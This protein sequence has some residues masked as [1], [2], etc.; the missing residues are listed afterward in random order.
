[1]MLRYLAVAAVSA[2]SVVGVAAEVPLLT[3][4]DVFTLALEHDP[5]YAAAVAEQAAGSQAYRIRRASVRPSLSANAGVARVDRRIESEF[6]TGGTGGAFEENY[7]EYN[8][9][10]SLTQP[11]FRWDL[12][13]QLDIGRVE[14]VAAEVALKRT[15]Q[16]LMGRLARAYVEVLGA[17]DG[18]QTAQSRRE[19]VQRQL[20]QVR[21]QVDV[22]A[23]AITGLREAEAEFDLSEAE[24]ID[25]QLR[26]DDAV[27]QLAR[28]IGT[29]AFEL[30]PVQSVEPLQEATSRPLADWLIAAQER[31]TNVVAARLRAEVARLDI[32]TNESSRLPQLDLT[33]SY[34]RND[35]SESMIGQD[36]EEGRIGLN[37]TVPIFTG[38]A[39]VARLDAAR[40]TYLQ[41][42][43][44]LRAARELAESEVRT[45]WR[46]VRASKRRIA[47]RE[48][49]MRSTRTALR[50]V[51]DG[52]EVGTRTLSDV[53]AAEQ[54]ALRAIQ[55]FNAAR[56]DYVVAVV[57]LK[58]AAGTV[59]DA[60]IP[61]IDAVFTGNE[62]GNVK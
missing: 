8:Y 9:G 46:T 39:N 38:G 48:R 14:V 54:S 6:F 34:G 22:G 36:A 30:A 17:N 26:V 62:T 59:T 41:R 12:L 57:D 40:A 10:V 11:L 7:D 42:S 53:L 3:P 27:D 18:L 43:E 4:D 49:A 35:T 61:K 24:V 56:H 13:S 1:M 52:Y 16:E 2:W 44:E 32:R 20:D 29:A 33:A 25:A 58:L 45:A 60:D 5:V 21:D 28:I 47:A 55:E 19:A 23:V 51:R 15:R 50:A 31:N 37:L